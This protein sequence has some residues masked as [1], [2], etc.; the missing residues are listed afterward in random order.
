MPIFERTEESKRLEQ[1]AKKLPKPIQWLL[2]DPYDPSSYIHPIAGLTVTEGLKQLLLPVAKSSKLKGL[3]KRSVWFMTADEIH[4]LARAWLHGFEEPTR[5]VLTKISW[6]P[7]S[8][9]F[10]RFYPHTFDI[11]LNVPHKF[12]Q[13]ERPIYAT[14]L[15]E[16]SHADIEILSRILNRLGKPPVLYPPYSP[17]YEALANWLARQKAHSIGL[18]FISVPE[19]E[20]AR[21]VEKLW[22]YFVHQIE[23]QYLPTTSQHGREA[24][25]TVINF[26]TTYLTSPERADDILKDISTYFINLRRATSF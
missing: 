13:K 19:S 21:G 10:G 18:P 25:E 4:N 7:M 12:R 6:R 23:R 9:E 2:P 15:H 5:R 1:Y 3:S 14:L 26:L 20:I 8:N 24:Y 11:V 16:G 17:I 22:P